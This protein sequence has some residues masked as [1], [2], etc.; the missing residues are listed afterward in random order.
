MNLE[1]FVRNSFNEINELTKTNNTDYYN[2]DYLRLLNN[3]TSSEETEVRE[4]IKNIIIG[5]ERIVEIQDDC[6]SR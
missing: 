3:C 6:Y 5:L 1:E 2:D 4:I